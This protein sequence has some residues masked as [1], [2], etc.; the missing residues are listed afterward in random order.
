VLA[1]R[2]PLAFRV[3]IAACFSL[4]QSNSAIVRRSLNLPIARAHLGADRGHLEER[5]KT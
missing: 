1:V 4:V 2:V 3:D 5:R